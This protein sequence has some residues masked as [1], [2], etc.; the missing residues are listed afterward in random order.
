MSWEQ[1]GDSKYKISN[2]EKLKDITVGGN[3][4]FYYA[5]FRIADKYKTVNSINGFVNHME[6]ENEVKNANTEIKNEILIGNKN[7]V[8]NVKNYISDIKLR[9][10]AVIAR[11]LLMSASPD[12][13]KGLSETDLGLWKA[14]NIKFLK[15]SFGDNCIYATLHKD[16]KTW[17]I[18]ALIV[19]KF[20]NKKGESI[21]SNTRYFDGVEHMRAWQDNYSNSMKQRFKCLNRGVKYSKAKHVEVRA[22]YAMIE[23]KL[24][25]NSHDQILAKARN[26]ELLEIKLKA[27]QYTLETYKKYNNKNELALQDAKILLK[28]IDKFKDDKDIYK[29]VVSLLSQ[30][31]EIPQYAIKEAIRECE[32]INNK[33]KEHE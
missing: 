23:K 33:E 20:K 29:D 26:S 27:V 8:N 1:F 25:V 22:W 2:K 13:F 14:V 28:Q 11:S 5:I 30:R 19:P 15:D 10:N 18:H 31:Y 32:N 21:L 4:N 9:K 17:H 16:E 12:F 6:R 7:V 24:D 3:S